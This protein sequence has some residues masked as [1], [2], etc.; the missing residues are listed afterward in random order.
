[1]FVSF[2]L[3][4]LLFIYNFAAI[5]NG[6]PNITV[7]YSELPS[8][9]RNCRGLSVWQQDG[10]LFRQFSCYPTNFRKYKYPQLVSN[11]RSGRGMRC[12]EAP[13]LWVR[14]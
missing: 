14:E 13:I 9:G 11:T 5:S 10:P 1:M 4:R 8:P 6:M 12:D 2:S 7:N 3:N